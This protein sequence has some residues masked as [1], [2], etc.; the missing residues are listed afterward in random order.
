MTGDLG[1]RSALP[2]DIPNLKSHSIGF[3][4]KLLATWV[5]MGFRNPKLPVEGEI[6]V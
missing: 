3:Y 5:A 4:A 1:D 6:N 2:G